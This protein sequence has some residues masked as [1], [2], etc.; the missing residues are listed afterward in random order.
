[1]FRAFF[2]VVETFS[3]LSLQSMSPEI[4]QQP[5]WQMAPPGAMSVVGSGQNHG[6]GDLFDTDDLFPSPGASN[7]VGTAT[8][9]HNNNGGGKS[10]NNHGIPD[11]FSAFS[12]G[13]A[14]ALS[15]QRGSP[16]EFDGD[17][18]ANNPFAF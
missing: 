11:A 13:L 18:D 14:P 8:S 1:M 2:K 6:H 9:S 5:S 15:A 7:Q 3:S 17:D 12:N 16:A 10:Q 4:E